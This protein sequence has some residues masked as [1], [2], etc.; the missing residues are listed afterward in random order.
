[1]SCNICSNPQEVDII[2]KDLNKKLS[3]VFKDTD[4]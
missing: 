1:M 4:C 3:I 2:A